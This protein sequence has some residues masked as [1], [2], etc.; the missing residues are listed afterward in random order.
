MGTGNIMGFILYPDT[1]LVQ[2]GCRG[3]F[4]F[5]KEGGLKKPITLKTNEF[6]LQSS[7]QIAIF[8]SGK[9]IT[10]RQEVLPERIGIDPLSTATACSEFP[11]LETADPFLQN[12]L[13]PFLTTRLTGICTG[14]GT[15]P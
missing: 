4:P 13:L 9:N 11:C 14:P 5:F 1:P 8:A 12:M 15:A 3:N 7:Q 2:P 10:A 6:L